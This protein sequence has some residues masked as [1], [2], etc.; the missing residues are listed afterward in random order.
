MKIH[1]STGNF[2]GDKDAAAHIRDTYLRPTLARGK[3]AL[4][5]FSHV[6]LAT[7]SFVHAL[8]AA[9]VRENPDSLEKIDFKHC[10]DAIKDIIQI[11]VEYAQDDFED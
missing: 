9:I 1:A 5:D 6:E 2:A 3:T 7:Q 10:N 11:V 4:L 8:L